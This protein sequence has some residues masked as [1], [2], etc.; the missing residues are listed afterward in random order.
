MKTLIGR[1]GELA[2]LARKLESE[3][4]VTLVGPAGIGKTSLA[5]AAIA[6][7]NEALFVD[8]TRVDSGAR[9]VQAL[10]AALGLVAEGGGAAQTSRVA[11]ALRL[12]HAPL[13]VLD[14]IE[15]VGRD[16]ISAIA[17]WLAEA[18]SARFLLTSRSALGAAGE[19]AVEVGPLAVP[20]RGSR[21]TTA[22]VELFIRA[23]QRVRPDYEGDLPVVAEIVRRLEG[24]PFAVTLAASRM[25]LLS[26]RALLETL[27]QATGDS[28]AAAIEWSWELLSSAE[29]AVLARSAVLDGSFGLDTATAV[30][31]EDVS[32]VID[33]LRAKSLLRVETSRLPPGEPRF[34]AHLG[35]REFALARLDDADRLDAEQRLAAHFARRFGDVIG[36]SAHKPTQID[37]LARVQEWSHLVSASKY[38]MRASASA[39]EREWAARLLLAEEPLTA[40]LGSRDDYVER[41]T[42]LIEGSS[43]AEL[44]SRIATRLCI[45]RARIGIYTGQFDE[46]LSDARRALEQARALADEGEQVL[47]LDAVGTAA[48][49]AG[50]LGAAQDAFQD[51]HE[52]ARRID[53]AILGDTLHGLTW[54]HL[55]RGELDAAER[56]LAQTAELTRRHGPTALTMLLL[57]ARGWLALE[58][59]QGIEAMDHMEHA[60]RVAESIENRRG[61]AYLLGCRA[62]FALQVG[63]TAGVADALEQAAA[64]LRR[65][66]AQRSVALF[67]LGHGVLLLRDGRLQE[68]R[69]LL[70]RAAR[71]PVS[72]DVDRAGDALEGLIELEL[73][74]R[75]RGAVSVELSRRAEERRDRAAGDTSV[76]VRWAARLLTAALSRAR[77]EA[78]EP[79]PAALVV[80][81]RAEWFVPP[82]DSRAVAI[83]RR[84][85]L[86]RILAACLES[87]GHDATLSV[88]ELA[89]AGWP[90]ERMLAAAA[91][92]R[93]HVAIATLRRLGLRDA[94]VHRDG[95]YGLDPALTVVVSEAPPARVRGTR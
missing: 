20:E 38:A 91:T 25:G 94:L 22:A 18:P 10:C 53:H 54:V 26:T 14:N 33:S 79:D 59:G 32:E 15:G 90:G 72:G 4:L 8:L 47:A 82:H 84:A 52:L 45:A 69:A 7:Q 23:A 73:A 31:G 34:S 42:R 6:G 81:P 93:V 50:K 67:R 30:F 63:D 65:Q 78:G 88:T 40:A 3:R 62:L 77:A 37:L 12:R 89:E 66:G 85:A 56:T 28:L 74:G 49:Y 27:P 2:L 44:D 24:N 86:R 39:Q 46:S 70:D 51:A 48:F 16:A 64:E 58:R 83:G 19:V 17:V 92:N 35:V 43:E 68:A 29:R 57:E 61:A 55:E 41:L 60:R 5:R 87:R 76:V 71:P 21:E 75:E 1:A 13:V 36:P 9:V 80:H 95:G 11:D